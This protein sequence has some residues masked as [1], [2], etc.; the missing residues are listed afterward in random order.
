MLTDHARANDSQSSAGAMSSHGNSQPVTDSQ[1][2]DSQLHPVESAI[3]PVATS[4]PTTGP[5]TGKPIDQMLTN[6]ITC[7]QSE[8][9]DR[10]L[11]RH[12]DDADG[13][14]EDAQPTPKICKRPAAAAKSVRKRPA[15]AL[16]DHD[17][18]DSIPKY[19]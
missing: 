19:P 3:V 14:I 9:L 16:V 18:V 2:N 4:M 15:A 13:T 1:G 8:K 6:V 7:F 11:K 10:N 17:D 12:A 5:I